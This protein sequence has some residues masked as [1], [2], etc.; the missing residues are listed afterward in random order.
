MFTQPITIEPVDGVYP[1]TKIIQTDESTLGYIK[2]TL[3]VTEYDPLS[4]LKQELSEVE[5]AIS[6]NDSDA[7]AEDER[8]KKLAS[9]RVLQKEELL[10]RKAF[11]ESESAKYNA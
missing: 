10:K 7:L 4:Q 6:Q 11:L 3:N 8:N 1:D 5:R 2:V 9:Q